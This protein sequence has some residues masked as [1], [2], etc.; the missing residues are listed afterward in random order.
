MTALIAKF[1]GGFWY[2]AAFSVPNGLDFMPVN[3]VAAAKVGAA[4]HYPE[5]H[6]GHAFGFISINS[7]QVI[8]CGVVSQPRTPG[9]SS[10]E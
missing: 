10:D 8:F 1:S 3:M 9:W 4:I 5:G 6:R 2:P 7:G